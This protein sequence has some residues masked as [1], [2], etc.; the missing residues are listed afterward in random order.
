MTYQFNIS[1]CRKIYDTNRIVYR[2]PTPHP[3]RR[4]AL[5]RRNRCRDPIR[6]SDNSVPDMTTDPASAPL[7]RGG[8]KTWSRGKGGSPSQAPAK[9]PPDD[10]TLENRTLRIVFCFSFRLSFPR[11]LLRAHEEPPFRDILNF[12]SMRLYDTTKIPCIWMVILQSIM[13][14]SE[15]L[16]QNDVLFWNGA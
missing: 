9:R 3:T 15:L 13:Y 10:S 11:L 1:V 12:L 6:Q 8:L 4:S 16:N 2:V 7:I 14:I 5:Y